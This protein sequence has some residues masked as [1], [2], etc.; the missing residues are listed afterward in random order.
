MGFDFARVDPPADIPLPSTP[1]TIG[2]G[3]SSL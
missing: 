3:T 1:A 2:A